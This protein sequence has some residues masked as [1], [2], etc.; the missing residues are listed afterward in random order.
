MAVIL[1][2][3]WSNICILIFRCSTNVNITINTTNNNGRNN[4]KNDGKNIN[5]R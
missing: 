3:C 4:C 2:Q 1:L 5:N